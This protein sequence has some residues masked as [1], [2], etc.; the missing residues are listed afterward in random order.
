MGEDE[1]VGAL[2]AALGSSSG[3]TREGEGE[4]AAAFAPPRAPRAA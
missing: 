2:C 1:G 4:G 3:D